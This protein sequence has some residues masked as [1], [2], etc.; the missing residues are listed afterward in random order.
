M[1]QFTTWTKIAQM[2]AGVGAFLR[3]LP[4]YSP[5]LNLIKHVFSKVKA[6]LKANNTVYL[7]TRSNNGILHH[8]TAILHQI[9]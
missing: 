7:T 2:I 4:P 1:P 6:F 8:Y 9:H 3:F 5:E